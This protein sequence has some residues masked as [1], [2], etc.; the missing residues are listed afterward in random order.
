MLGEAYSRLR[1]PRPFLDDRGRKWFSKMGKNGAPT[2]LGPAPPY[3]TGARTS[4]P[5]VKGDTQRVTQDRSGHYS[6][7]EWELAGGDWV[8]VYN[9]YS[10]ERHFAP[11]GSS[12]RYNPYISGWE[13]AGEDWVIV[14]N[15]Y[16]EERHFALPGSS[17]RY[18]PYISGWELA[19]EDWVIEYN[20]HTGQW[21]P[22]R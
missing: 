17:P 9:V 14:Y 6:T 5:L 20:P 19:G 4:Q 1:A 2:A 15:V 11:P 10:E 21:R 8:I 16:S 3:P 18:N 12:P 22:S 7:G 13:L